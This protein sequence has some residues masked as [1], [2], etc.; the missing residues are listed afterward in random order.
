MNINDEW[1]ISVTMRWKSRERHLFIN[2]SSKELNM[3]GVG[4]RKI[5]KEG[6]YPPV[7]TYNSALLNVLFCYYNGNLT[8]R[9]KKHKL[10]YIKEELYIRVS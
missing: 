6:C 5:I 1:V 9:K 4:N 10:E 2:L 3:M 8:N 7:Y